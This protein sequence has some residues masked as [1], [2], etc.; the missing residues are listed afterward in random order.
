MSLS[1]LLITAAGVAFEDCRLRGADNLMRVDARCGVVEVPVDHGDPDGELLELRVAKLPATERSQEKAPIV[2][3]AG[4]PG[5]AATEAFV[6]HAQAFR[7][8]RRKH[9]LILVDQRGTGGSGALDCPTDRAMEIEDVEAARDWAREC[10]GALEEQDKDPR[11]YLTRDAV[12]DLEA[13]RETLEVDAWHLYGVSYGTRLAQEYLREHEEH[14][15]GFVLDG[16]VPVG[17]AIGPMIGPFAQRALDQMF[18]RCAEDE[19]CAEA[20]PELEDQFE[21]L[22]GELEDAPR[23]VAIRHPRSGEPEQIE[24]SRDSVSQMIRLAS[25]QTEALALVPL[26]IHRVAAEEDWTPLAGQVAL[27]ELTAEGLLNPALH[28]AVLCSEDRQLGMEPLETE[29]AGYLGERPLEMLRAICEEWPA[30]EAG[31]DFGES[32]GVEREGVVLSGELD[33]VTPPTWGEKTAEMLGATHLEVP[34]KAHGVGHLGCLPRVL[35]DY[36]Q[37]GN[38]QDMDTDCL[39]NLRPTPFFLDFSG[40]AP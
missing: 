29:G 5:Q 30:G 19:H 6:G 2:M 10:L 7:P 37:E 20:F 33:P 24:L 32:F 40:P 36:F 17:E 11:H 4:G 39:D 13:V 1:V 25:Y 31:Q 35:R 18:A 26:L 27:M 16:A 14:V 38:P 8:I 12:A 34:G 23:E 9:P 15:A 21:S 28:Y 3:L 22:L